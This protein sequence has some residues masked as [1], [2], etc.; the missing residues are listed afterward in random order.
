MR[1]KPMGMLLMMLAG[2]INRHQQDVITKIRVS[3][4]QGRSVSEVVPLMLDIRQ[5]LTAGWRRPRLARGELKSTSVIRPPQKSVP[6][7]RSV[8]PQTPGRGTRD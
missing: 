7:L 5:F 4:V 1:V 2:W 6:P 3:L 8:R